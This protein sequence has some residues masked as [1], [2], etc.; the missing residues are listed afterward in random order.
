LNKNFL[1]RIETD[2]A[3]IMPFTNF[4][5]QEVE[6]KSEFA[7]NHAVV[8]NLTQRFIYPS[9]QNEKSFMKIASKLCLFVL[10]FI[11]CHKDQG[12]ASQIDCNILQVYADNAKKVT[13]TN[14]V[15]GTVSS[16]EGDCM[17]TVPACNSCCRNCPVQRIVRIYQYTLLSD[18]VTSDPYNV[19][20]DSFNTQLIAQV[21]TDNNGFFQADISP[22]IYSIVV[23]ENGKLYANTRDGQ[24]GLSPFTFTT[25]TQNVNLTMTY[26]ATF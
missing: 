14:G 26:K 18:A 10:F 22:A 25:A 20:F 17:P 6:N 11:S 4:L 21:D 3:G 9:C 12:R 5:I 16:V 1:C 24:G 13:I 7:I 15:W 8:C 2:G 19:F 23:V